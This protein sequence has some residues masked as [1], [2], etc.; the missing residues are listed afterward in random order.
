[1]MLI[2]TR[3]GSGNNNVLFAAAS[4]EYLYNPDS[5]VESS[6]QM[7]TATAAKDITARKRY[8]CNTVLHVEVVYLLQGLWSSRPVYMDALPLSSVGEEGKWRSFP[9]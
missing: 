8:C 6:G 2:T 3:R 5:A 7:W 4:G 9:S 1:M